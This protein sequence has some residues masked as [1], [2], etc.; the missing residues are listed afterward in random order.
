MK[1]PVLGLLLFIS[2]TTIY[3]QKTFEGTVTY[4]YTIK[5]ENAGMMASFMPEKMIMIYDKK[6]M[7]TS[8]EGGMLANMMGKIVVDAV[9]NEAFV[10]KEAEKTVYLMKQEDMD[11]VEEPQV[12]E[13]VKQEGE[14]DILGYRCHRYKMVTEAEGAETVQHIWVTN[15]LKTPDLKLPGLGN[16]AGGVL[17][18]NKLPGFPMQ[19]EVAIANMDA[20]MIMTATEI[21]LKRVDKQ[22]FLRPKDFTVKDFS[23]LLGSGNRE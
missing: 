2:I 23:E 9:N 13:M 11:N 10:V 19:I 15:E 20:T 1:I 4:S 12:K 5:G 18:G 8:M 6:G 21:D 3:A 7:I 14:E 16:M 17:S 22:V